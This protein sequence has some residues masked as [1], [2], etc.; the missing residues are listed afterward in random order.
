VLPSARCQKF[1]ELE[2]Y[3]TSN[4][5]EAEITRL[6]DLIQIADSRSPRV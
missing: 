4:W 2:L 6:K 1:P 3:A 5:G